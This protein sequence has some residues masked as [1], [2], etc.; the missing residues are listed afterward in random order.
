MDLD[1]LLV[2]L[3]QRGG[4][5]LHIKTGR[6]PLFRISGDLVPQTTYSEISAE[7]MKA[8]MGRLMGPE[9]MRVFTQEL[10]ADFSYEI[11]GYARFRVNAFIQR[12]LIGAVMRL[13]PLEVPTIDGMG[14]PDVLKDLCDHPNGLCIV[15]GPTGSGKSTTLAAMIQYINQKF[16]NHIITIEDPIEFVY[17]DEL[18]TINQRELG[19]DTH[20]LHR[21][22]RA[23]LR[24]D[25]DVI[26]M[27]EMRDAETI[28]FAITAAET[29]HL[30]F[31]TLHTNDAKQSL[32]R[33][34]DTFEGPEANQV[35]MQ[36]AL[37]LRG[38]VSQR[39]VKRADG[40][41]RVA[42]IEIMLNTSYIKQLIEEGSTRD[43][44]KAI[45]EGA[46]HK[47]Q[48]FNQAL[49][50]LWSK[51]LINET[52]ALAS[53]STPEDLTLMF[54]GIKRGTSAGEAMEHASGG[55]A[56]S[57]GPSGASV[58]KPKPSFG[59]G[60]KTLQGPE[61]QKKPPSRGFDF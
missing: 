3:G 13:V 36:L 45:T 16:Q 9:R 50:A 37:V 57:V 43:L 58:I 49:Y 52:E 46:H 33:I 17:T 15:T 27:G 30:V 39:L 1:A 59:G 29:G 7:D 32:D 6:P 24:Q 22:L 34:L 5:D 25:P 4:S 2:E 41:G 55:A 60:A 31:S 19:L 61:G 23:A 51:G 48:T 12:G 20:E 56:P 21:A 40:Q 38:V 44:E 28:H 35:R 47:M 10:E 11:P 14:L 54:R 8:T 18:S 26:L 42:A 53:S